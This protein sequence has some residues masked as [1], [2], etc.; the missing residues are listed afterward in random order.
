M[1]EE[2]DK[3]TEKNYNTTTDFSTTDY[4]VALQYDKDK[5]NAPVVAAKGQGNVA[6]KIIELAKEN[7]IE[8]RQDADLVQILKLVNINEEIPM[9]AFAAVAEILSYIYA[10]N[11]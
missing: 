9:E 3:L 8:I 4:A 11:K 6:A 7:G 5:H 2:D 10:Q 1:S